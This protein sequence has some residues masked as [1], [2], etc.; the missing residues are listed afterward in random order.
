MGLFPTIRI[1]PALVT[2]QPPVAKTGKTVPQRGA[3]V[4]NVGRTAAPALS[5]DV[6]QGPDRQLLHIAGVRA[7]ELPRRKRRSARGLLTEGGLPPQD[8]VVV[9]GEAM[10]LVADVLQQSQRKRVAAQA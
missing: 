4:P 1:Y 7:P 8:V 9:L 5:R 3:G 10:G 6:E 2:L